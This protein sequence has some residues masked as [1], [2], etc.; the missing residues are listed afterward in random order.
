MTLKPLEKLS[1]TQRLA[2]AF[3]YM[4]PQQ[5]M[6]QLAGW[7]AKKEWGAVTHFTI[8]LFAKQYNVNMAEA[9]KTEYSDYK[10]FNEFFIRQLKADARPIVEDEKTLC[11]PADGC[12]SELGT[13]EDNL[14]LQAKGHSFSLEDLLANDLEL[15]ELFKNGT[16]ATTYLSPSDY[17]RVHMPCAGTLRKMIYVPGDLFSVNPFLASHIPNLFARNERVICLFD[18]PV[19]KMV[20]ILVGATITASMSTTWAGVINPPRS[21]SVRVWTYQDED[22]SF[23][24]GQEM[25]AFQLGSTVI[26]LFQKDSVQLEEYLD[27]ASVVKMGEALA[28]QK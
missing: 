9:E 11:F 8:K 2:V 15:V 27:V 17:H 3:Q 23:D 6:T 7:F 1:Y 14:L 19:G 20:Q 26:N 21:E 12:V 22:I 10:S 5:Y 16:F 18:T 28:R 24:K 13:I 25:G 4:M